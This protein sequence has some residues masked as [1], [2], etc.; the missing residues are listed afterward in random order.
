MLILIQANDSG[1]TTS[2]IAVMI[3]NS[4]VQFGRD[5]CFINRKIIHK[6]YI[7][8]RDPVSHLV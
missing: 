7:G 3:D 6:Y 8:I 4:D 1:K 5:I 2:K